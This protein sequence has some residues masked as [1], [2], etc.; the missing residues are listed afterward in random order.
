MYK[1][2][3]GGEVERGNYTPSDFAGSPYR[4]LKDGKWKGFLSCDLSVHFS[5]NL[6]SLDQ[7]P[8]Q[9][10]A[11][12]RRAFFVHANTCYGPFPLVWGFHQ[13][14]F[15]HTLVPSAVENERVCAARNLLFHDPAYDVDVRIIWRSRAKKLFSRFDEL[16]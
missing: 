9:K 10:C 6:V 3:R 15:H 7:S 13:V 4:S 5:S 11:S 16:V 14:R 2:V 12:W 8:V 1:I